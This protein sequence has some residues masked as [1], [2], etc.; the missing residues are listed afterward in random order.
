MF[1]KCYNKL[2]NSEFINNVYAYLHLFL[3]I[4]KK[5]RKLFPLFLKSTL[6]YYILGNKSDVTFEFKWNQITMPRHLKWLDGLLIDSS[7][8]III[9]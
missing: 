5:E 8:K 6:S 4:L 7:V 1:P 2:K 3:F 9:S